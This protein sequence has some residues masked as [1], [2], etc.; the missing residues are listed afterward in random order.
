LRIEH[1]CSFAGNSQTTMPRFVSARILQRQMYVAVCCDFH[2]DNAASD[3]THIAS[4]PMRFELCVI[5]TPGPRQLRT[6]E[7]VADVITRSGSD[8]I[9]FSDSDVR[10]DC[11]DIRTVNQK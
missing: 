4:I 11:H 8:G 7:G 3:C 5:C 6:S 2:S 9:V 10:R 1:H